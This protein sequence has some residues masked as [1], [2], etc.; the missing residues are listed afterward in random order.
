MEVELLTSPRVCL[1]MDLKPGPTSCFKPQW[2]VLWNR[3]R[4]AD[5]IMCSGW[6]E[7]GPKYNCGLTLAHSTQ[8]GRLRPP[9]SYKGPPVSLRSRERRKTL[10][11]ISR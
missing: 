4:L 8:I 6:L 2:T 1:N 10:I 5:E 7:I 11:V 9:C 3:V